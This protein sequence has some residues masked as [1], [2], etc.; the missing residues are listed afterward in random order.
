MA[1][2]FDVDA[3]G[4]NQKIYLNGKLDAENRSANPL[5]TNAGP[6]FIGAETYT[7]PAG[8]WFFQGMID[9]GSMY[10][11]ALNPVEIKTIAGVKPT[12][13]PT[14]KDGATVSTTD[15]LLEWWQGSNVAA[16][17]GHHVYFSDQMADV[18]NSDAKADKG[19]TT[20]PNYLVK[21]LTPGATYYWRVDE[22]NE[23]HPDKIWRGPGLEL[24]RRHR[25]SRRAQ[26]AGRCSVR[27]PQPDSELGAG[28]RG[29][30]AP[31][32]FQHRP[33]QG[34]RRGGGG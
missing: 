5:T 9:E 27:E 12:T 6:L 10:N 8:R 14:P 33:D 34:R 17:N 19:F 13:D 16:K 21:G 31:R 7:Q 15:V 29:G 32:L 24:H 2:T 30:V 25:E 26:S 22:V 3:P 1:V 18:N 23:V 4:N 20:D 11:R 28:H